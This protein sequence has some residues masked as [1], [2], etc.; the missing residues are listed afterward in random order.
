MKGILHQPCF[1]VMQD[2]YFSVAV[3][4][5]K[6]KCQ[7]P[8]AKYNGSL[9]PSRRLRCKSQYS[10]LYSATFPLVQPAAYPTMSSSDSDDWSPRNN[11]RQYSYGRNGRERPQEKDARDVL[12]AIFK[13]EINSFSMPLP[14]WRSSYC[15]QM[16]K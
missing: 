8:E 13:G 3:G 5:T 10:S 12:A 15:K 9:W 1:L 11:N 4:I 16:R 14:Y 6:L 7:P 2:A